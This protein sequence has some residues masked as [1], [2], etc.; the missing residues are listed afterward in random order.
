MHQPQENVATPFYLSR[1]LT[2]WLSPQD[3]VTLSCKDPVLACQRGSSVET[4]RQDLRFAGRILRNN[5]G[6]TLVVVLTLALGIGATSGILALVDAV[7]I[8]P[9]P[10]LDPDRVALVWE[11]QPKQNN[12]TRLVTLA[13]FF[14]WRDRNHVFQ[15]MSACVPLSPPLPGH[16]EPQELAG[17]RASANF[18]DLLGVKAAVGRSFLA[19]E[20]QPGHDQVVMLSHRLWKRR[21]GADPNVIGQPVILDENP[22]IIVGVVPS[23]F[24]LWGTGLQYDLWVPLS[25]FRTQLVRDNHTFTVFGRLKFSATPWKADSEMDAIVRQLAVEYPAKDQDV[26][27]RVIRLHD[28]MTEKVRPAL[29]LLFLS[30]LFV[31]AIG[32]VNVANLLLARALKREREMAL[33]AS[34]GAGRARPLPQLL[35]ESIVLSLAGGALGVGLAAVGIHLL[36]MLAQTKTELQEVR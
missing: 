20:E 34:L 21:F 2:R 27:A 1:N 30:A 4:L 22:Y 15:E 18:F 14:D 36:P 9:V 24:S 5:S 28:E 19:D 23:D 11:T 31:L 10:F 26:G 33:R 35:T 16:S 7:L 25:F 32:W 13:D 6:F 29:Q 17:A 3:I 8:R 12:K